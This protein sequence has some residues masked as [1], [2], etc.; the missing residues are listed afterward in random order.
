MKICKCSKLDLV[1]IEDLAVNCNHY[2]TIILMFTNN[3]IQD[4]I[5]SQ[6][7]YICVNVLTKH[8]VL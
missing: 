1:F 3:I 7:I 5:S 2:F 4:D 8:V 6:T